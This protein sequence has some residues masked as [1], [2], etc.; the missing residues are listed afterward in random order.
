MTTK[1]TVEVPEDANYIARIK[2]DGVNAFVG[3]GQTWSG[4]IYGENAMTIN[5]T[6]NRVESRV[7][8]TERLVTLLKEIKRID[9]RMFE[10][11]QQ[12]D[13]LVDAIDKKQ[14]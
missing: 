5:E 8:N 6:R 13:F 9:A 7:E 11:Q 3:A 14:S 12:C 4:Y 2:A 1:V 10:L